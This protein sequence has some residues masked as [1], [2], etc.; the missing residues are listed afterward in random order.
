MGIQILPLLLE[1]KEFRIID[2]INQINYRE[3]FKG[4]TL[5]GTIDCM[6]MLIYRM[7][8]PAELEDLH[9]PVECVAV[10]TDVV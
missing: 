1:E 9:V 3:T 2:I 7:A 8:L 6:A 4:D 10:V 5:K